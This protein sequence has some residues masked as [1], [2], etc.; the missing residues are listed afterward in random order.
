MKDYN[1]QTYWLSFNIRSFLPGDSKFPAWLNGA[2]GYGAN[3]MIG[4]EKN[5][6]T[7]NGKNIPAFKRIRQFYIAADADFNKIKT[8]NAA[9]AP[10][11]FLQFIKTPSPAIEYN[12]QKK[13]IFHPVQ[14]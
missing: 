2:I 9:S 7:I 1:G 10:L 3:G 11:Y 13:I 6:E 8:S 4:G 12:T 14:F 5:S